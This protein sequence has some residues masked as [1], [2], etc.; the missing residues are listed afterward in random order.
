MELPSIQSGLTLSGI[1]S[2]FASLIWHFY[3]SFWKLPT[4][5]IKN[6][7]LAAKHGIYGNGLSIEI[8]NST[9]TP[10]II[11]K[12][13]KVIAIPLI[14]VK[15]KNK[16]GTK[17]T[18]WLEIENRDSSYVILP[19]W[20]SESYPVSSKSKAEEQLPLDLFLV[21]VFISFHGKL[22]KRSALLYH[23]HE[24][25]KDLSF[26]QYWK[27]R[28]IF[29]RLSRNPNTNVRKIEKIIDDQIK[30]I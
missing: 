9:S 18:Y 29:W 14:S 7:K 16:F 27:K 26:W 19:A 23:L 25:A 11:K 24:Q 8:I 17:K 10:C 4:I 30:D 22:R 3:N 1:L 28:I 21:K 5:K 2:G 12:N 15:K 20:S 6:F 13:V